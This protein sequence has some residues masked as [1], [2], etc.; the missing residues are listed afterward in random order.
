MRWLL[1]VALGLIGFNAFVQETS[2]LAPP[3]PSRYATKGVIYEDVTQ[4]S[5]LGSFRHTGGSPIKPYLPDFNGSGVALLDYDN[6]GWLDIYLVNAQSHASRTGQVPPLRAALFHNN[7]DGTFTDVTERA[8]VENL[9]WGTGVCAGD[10]D[11]DGWEDLFVSN[12]GKSRLYRNNGNGAF[13]DIAAEAGVQVD[14]WAT[15]CAFGDYDADGRLDLYVATYVDFDWNHPPPS[16]E[17]EQGEMAQGRRTQPHQE[18]DHSRGLRSIATFLHVL[19]SAGRMRSDGPQTRSG[20]S[21][22]QQRRPH[23]S[24][25][26]PRER[27]RG[28][29]RPLRS[30]RRL[31]GR[32]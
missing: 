32:R 26:Y 22:S 21:V 23:I 7:H 15:G 12:L 6:D 5:G 13:T 4:V 14:M 28:G 9:R 19:R 16:G 31:G 3:A 18:R 25:R 29:A 17:W 20:F 2:T 1:G 8:G 30:R 10:F 27:H 24:R 11:N